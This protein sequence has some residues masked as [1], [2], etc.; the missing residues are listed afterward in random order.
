MRAVRLERRVGYSAGV[1]HA[2]L[3]GKIAPEADD[4]ERR[5]DVLTSTVFGTLFA[6]GAWDVV[7]SWLLRGRP[8]G[9]APPLAIGPV[10]AEADYWFWPRLDDTRPGGIVEPDLIIAVG[11][12]I[13]IVEA[14]YYAGK[15]GKGTAEEPQAEDAEAVTVDQLVRQW[16]ACGSGAAAG[17]CAATLRDALQSGSPRALFYLVR[18]SRW[19]RES[20]AA[21]VSAREASDARIYLLSWEDL[22]D[23]LAARDGQRWAREM[24]SYLRRRDLAAFR[25]FESAVGPSAAVTMLAASRPRPARRESA[26]D[27][28]LPAGRVSGLAALAAWKRH[29]IKGDE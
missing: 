12:I 8:V 9:K 2:D 25:G 13:A 20:R 27:G 1:L 28:V 3:H 5:E 6:V 15:S 7:R 18:R 26:W 19:P 23:V 17:R 21:A 11:G 22:D 24:R 29:R 10:E 14:K 16:R 4:A